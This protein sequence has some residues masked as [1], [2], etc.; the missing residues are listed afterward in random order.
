M[1]DV[2]VAPGKRDLAELVQQLEVWLG[3]KI[4]GSSAV[5]ITNLDYPRGAGQSHETLLFDAAWQAGD[6]KQQR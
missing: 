2:I 3:A 5:S 6:A 1:S 4:P